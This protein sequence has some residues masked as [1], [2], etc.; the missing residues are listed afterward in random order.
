MLK[1]YTLS[2]KIQTKDQRVVNDLFLVKK[3]C[4]GKDATISR[5]LAFFAEIGYFFM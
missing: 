2:G 3:Y 4:F 5:S 1:T